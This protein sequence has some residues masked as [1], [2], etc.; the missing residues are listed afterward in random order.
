MSANKSGLY[1]NYY[2]SLTSTEWYCENFHTQC[3]LTERP[4]T[5]LITGW[6]EFYHVYLHELSGELWGP[7]SYFFYQIYPHKLK[8]HG[9]NQYLWQYG[10][11]YYC[12][13]V[14]QHCLF[15]LLWSCW[16]RWLGVCYWPTCYCLQTGYD[17]DYIGRD[18][19][20]THVRR[21]CQVHLFV[22]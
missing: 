14:D 13:E 10:F 11:I 21:P 18:L 2:K 9:H 8:S 3:T 19:L 1:I 16:C 20:P 22:C 6:V 12:L 7:W 5:F 4:H 15:G 17:L